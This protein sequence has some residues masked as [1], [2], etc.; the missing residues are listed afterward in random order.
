MDLTL[1]S[2]SI[3]VFKFKFS[4]CLSL[5]LSLSLSL[6]PSFPPSSL[7]SL[8]VSICLFLSLFECSVQTP[9][10]CRNVAMS[11][12]PSPPGCWKASLPPAR[13]DSLGFHLV[14]LPAVDVLRSCCQYAGA[15]F[16]GTKFCVVQ[17]AM[18]CVQR[19][20]GHNGPPLYSLVFNLCLCV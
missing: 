10:L 15:E 2:W 3:K 18:A 8:C 4:L 7:F 9:V 14:G 20:D 13:T 11:L 5:Y 19:E 1:L 12:L 16:W 17:V 6:S